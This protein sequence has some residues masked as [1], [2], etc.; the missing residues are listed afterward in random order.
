[1]RQWCNFMHYLGI[2]RK[3]LKKLRKSPVMVVG[4]LADI[5]TKFF[6]MQVKSAVV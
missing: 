6:K 2:L 1:M 5:R 3:K 4:V